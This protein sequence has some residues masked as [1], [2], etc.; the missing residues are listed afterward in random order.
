ME[1]LPRLA[2]HRKIS[3]LQRG[4]RRSGRLHGPRSARRRPPC[5]ARGHVHRRLRH[6]RQPRLHLHQGRIS[7]RHR[8]PA[9]R[10]GSDARTRPARR[11]YSRQ[12]L[13]LR[14]GHQGRRRRFR[15]RRGDRAH[16]QHRGQPRHAQG[17]PAVPGG[18][19]PVRQADQ[20]QQCRDLRQPAG[21]PAR[22]RRLV[23]RLRYREKQRHQD[24]RHHRQDQPPRPHRSTDGHDA[25]RRGVRRG[26]RHRGRRPVQ[27]GAD[28]RPFGRLHSRP[29]VGPAD[30]LRVA[31]GGRFDHGLGRAGRHGRDHL[32]GRPRA[33]LRELHRKR[34]RA[35][36]ARP[37]ALAPARCA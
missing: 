20:H 31:G 24:L 33:L 36:N 12:R 37:A 25:A 19:R 22:G 13:F 35:E 5:R 29:D 1:I 23:R 17:A 2:G 11:Q 30:Q 15:L 14:S 7:A 32:H 3:H 16:R 10:D 27:G 28:R 9:R 34:V 21:H 8:T 6:R 4:R 18:Q 26:R